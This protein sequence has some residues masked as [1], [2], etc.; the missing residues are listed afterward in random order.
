M[1]GY[2]PPVCRTSLFRKTGHTIRP[3]V[4]KKDCCVCNS[5]F[6][7]NLLC[8]FSLYELDKLY[9]RD[10]E[11]CETDCNCVLG[12]RNGGKA[13]CACKEG[14]FADQRGCEQAADC[15]P[16]VFGDIK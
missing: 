11:H 5:L 4:V 7:R 2:Y 6:Y 10:G 15:F 14:Y 13:E 8:E 3:P 1:G 9:D 12:E 16:Q